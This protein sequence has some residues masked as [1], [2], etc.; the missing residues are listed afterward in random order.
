MKTTTQT[1]TNP[2][3][4]SDSNKRYYT[5]D[6]YLKKKFGGKVAKIPLDCGFTCPNIDGSKG[7]GGCIYCSSRGSGDFAQPSH[8]PLS[9]QYK[10]TLAIMQKKWNVQMTIPYFQAHT[11][12]YAD[13]KILK[14]HFYEVLDFEE[15]VG[16]S[17][18]TR[19]DCLPDEVIELLS[20]LAQK[21]TLT[22]ELGLQSVHDNTG[23]IINR[24]H[25]YSEFLDGYFKLRNSSSKIDICVHLIEGLPNENHSMMIESAKEVAS[26]APDQIKIHC[27]NVLKNT[28]LEQLYKKG[29]YSPITMQEY[30]EIVCDTLEVLPPNTVI[31]RLTGDADRNLL[32]EP[33]WTTRKTEVINNIDKEMYKRN[34]YQGKL[35]SLKSTL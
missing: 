10:K 5:Y 19:A 29:S 20:D 16:V 30:I 28:A 22:V 9:Q 33:L 34:S 23:K 12:T 3:I 11:N 6:Y 4:N 14:K 24:C 1:S 7:V 35:Y 21:T 32:V 18:A 27:L 15:T 13:I 17:I 26:L 2:F 25:T 31:G 8:I